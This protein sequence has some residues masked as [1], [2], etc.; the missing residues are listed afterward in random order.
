MRAQKEV[1][2]VD[3]FITALYEFAEYYHYVDFREEIM[4]DGL[5]VGIR[6]S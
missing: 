6:D 5:V 4:G 3:R 1:E 2:T